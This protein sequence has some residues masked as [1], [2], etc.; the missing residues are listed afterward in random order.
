MNDADKIAKNF[1][2]SSNESKDYGLVLGSP[3]HFLQRR[4]VVVKI[5]KGR[6]PDLGLMLCN[7]DMFLERH[8]TTIADIKRVFNDQ[9][10]VLTKE[11]PDAHASAR[12]KYYG[13]DYNPG[14][15]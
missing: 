10:H 4:K 5:I 1:P 14:G 12:F 3:E 11:A 9:Y 8:G 6:K 13:P 7:Y 2:E 15:D